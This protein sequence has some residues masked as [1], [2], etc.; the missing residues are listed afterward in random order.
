MATHSSI[1]AGKSHGQKSLAG[2]SSW[3]CKRVRHDLV[4]KEQIVKSLTPFYLTCLWCFLIPYKFKEISTSK[5]FRSVIDSRI[6][7]AY[8]HILAW[9]KFFQVIKNK[10]QNNKFINYSTVIVSEFFLSF[11]FKNELVGITFTI[12]SIHNFSFVLYAL[13]V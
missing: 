7:C 12:N 4:T 1:L 8:L 5:I 3:G 11:I 2:Y 10:W 9:E 13:Y 6:S